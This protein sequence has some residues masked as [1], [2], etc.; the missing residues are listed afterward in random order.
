MSQSSIISILSGKGGVGKTTIALNIARTISLAEQVVL[1]DLDIA[2]RGCTG[3]LSSWQQLESAD[4]YNFLNGQSVDP[5]GMS[6]IRNG[7]SEKE[8]R[9][10][11]SKLEITTDTNN[12]QLNFEESISKLEEL[13]SI[14]EKSIGPSTIIIDCHGGLEPL[15]LAA[16]YLSTDACI[17]TEPD[18]ATFSGTEVLVSSLK[19]IEVE[20]SEPTKLHYIINK[21]PAGLNYSDL[22]HL[23]MRLTSKG[24]GVLDSTANQ[25]LIFIPA[26]K[27]LL[28]TFGE[29]PF[30]VD[31]ARYS[32]FR[33]KIE[34]LCFNISSEA[35]KS[36]SNIKMYK[37]KYLREKTAKSISSPED[38]AVDAVIY[39]YL[40][41][42]VFLFAL[43]PTQ[44]YIFE[45]SDF[46]TMLYNAMPVIFLIIGIPVAVYGI[47][48]GFRLIAFLSGRA[49]MH[50]RVFSYSPSSFSHSIKALRHSVAAI[51]MLMVFSVPVIWSLTTDFG[52]NNLLNSEL[53]GLEEF[54]RELVQ[55]SNTNGP[56]AQQAID[57]ALSANTRLRREGLALASEVITGS[58]SGSSLSEVELININEGYYYLVAGCDRD[59]DGL[60]IEEINSNQIEIMSKNEGDT[61][62]VGFYSSVNQSIEITLSTKNCIAAPCFYA[63]AMYSENLGIQQS[64]IDDSVDFG[65]FLALE[66]DELPEISMIGRDVFQGN[67][68]LSREQNGYWVRVLSSTAGKITASSQDADTTLTVYSENCEF[69]NTDDDGGEG[70]N[71]EIN[72]SNAETGLIVNIDEFYQNYDSIF[73]IG[74]ITEIE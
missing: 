28:E 64:G 40:A 62:E 24:L 41:I 69:R 55:S 10:L 17:V 49:L 27:Y 47:Y 2:N 32:L 71:S 44:L 35:M 8:F 67:I 53:L 45:K 60:R 9:F 46:D 11:P 73:E 39:S 14:I 16:Y 33:R 65:C 21:V 63:I 57:N 34:L 50:W 52:T 42:L 30:Q 36:S 25:N 68:L 15:V 5:N 23:Y 56:Y 74:V 7:K 29:Y 1:I 59:C 48:G 3:I 19:S 6:K 54:E 70:F 66:N 51:G 26:E 22:M 31:L 4:V 38:K 12:I 37:S 18:I 43:V 72:F 58:F 61:P 20:K 13:I